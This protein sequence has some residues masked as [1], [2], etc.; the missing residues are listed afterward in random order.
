MRD[1]PSPAPHLP[2]PSRGGVGGGGRTAADLEQA[3]F[4]L[5]RF[6][7]REV[8]TGTTFLP[9]PSVAAA[10]GV[11]PAPGPSLREGREIA[12]GEVLR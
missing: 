7:G 6:T 9:G 10:G 12:D 3:V 1:M 2:S 5:L 8:M 4:R 11:F